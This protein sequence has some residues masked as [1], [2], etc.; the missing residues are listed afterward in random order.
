MTSPNALKVS[1]CVIHEPFVQIPIS[2]M[3]VTEVFI[4]L[5]L[6]PVFTYLIIQLNGMRIV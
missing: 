2:S 3:D 6:Y 4:S 5:L 1:P